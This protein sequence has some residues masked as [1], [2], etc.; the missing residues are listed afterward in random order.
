LPNKSF[1][2]KKKGGGQPWEKWRRQPYPW[3]ARATRAK[4][5][6]RSVRG[7]AGGGGEESINSAERRGR[8]PFDEARKGGGVLHPSHW[9]EERS[10]PAKKKKKE[11]NHLR[12]NWVVSVVIFIAKRRRLQGEKERGVSFHSSGKNGEGGFTA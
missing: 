2:S 8:G 12:K 5:G 1:I 6:V 3:K 10:S 11:G 9:W 7:E 4:E